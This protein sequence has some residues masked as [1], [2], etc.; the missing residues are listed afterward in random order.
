MMREEDQKWWSDTE[1]KKPAFIPALIVIPFTQAWQSGGRSVK[2]M[3]IE[4]TVY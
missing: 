4:L 1:Q 3:V 2:T